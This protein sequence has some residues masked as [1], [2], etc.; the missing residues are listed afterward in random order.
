M[1]VEI[2]YE[3][4]DGEFHAE[5]K[6]GNVTKF[7]VADNLSSLFYEMH[8]FTVKFMTRKTED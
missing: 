8:K 4:V 7:I 1:K 2:K 6:A 3:Q 5:I